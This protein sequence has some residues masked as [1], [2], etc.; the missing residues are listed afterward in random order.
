L[1]YYGGKELADSFRTVR[2]NTITIAEDIPEDKYSFRPA[3]D[4]RSVSELLIHITHGHSFQYQIHAEERRTSLDGQLNFPAIMAAKMA[5]EKVPR[6]KAQILELLRSTGELW[7]GWLEQLTDGFLGESVQ[8]RPGMVPAAKS[9][10]EM[11]IAVKEHEMH[12]R[13]QLILIERM[14]G[15]V[16]HLTRQLQARM[17]TVSEEL[18]R[19]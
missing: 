16:P 15:V 1:I 17:A 10:F 5:D 11:I 7:S 18:K 13:A 3:P 8:M 6:N 14:L 2:K 9:R 19:K 4:T 12:H